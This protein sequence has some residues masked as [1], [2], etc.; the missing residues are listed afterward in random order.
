MSTL[1]LLF[2]ITVVKSNVFVWSFPSLPQVTLDLIGKSQRPL[3]QIIKVVKISTD[4]LGKLVVSGVVCINHKSTVDRIGERIKFNKRVF[5]LHEVIIMVEE[6]F[7]GKNVK[8][9][10][11]LWHK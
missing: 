5:I 7:R 2:V 4:K 10:W 8:I 1:F 3:E 6:L 9:G 11:S